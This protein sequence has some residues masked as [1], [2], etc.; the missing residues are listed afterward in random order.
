MD[1]LD[2]YTYNGDCDRCG[3]GLMGECHLQC[4]HYEESEENEEI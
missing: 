3:F 2:E 1:W 4:T